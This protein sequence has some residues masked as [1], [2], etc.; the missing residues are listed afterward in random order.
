M[1]K[2]VIIFAPNKIDIYEVGEKG[3][4][5][6][7]VEMHEVYI[8]FEKSIKAYIDMSYIYDKDTMEA[9]T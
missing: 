6:I 3:V 7:L 8:Y 2:K 1:I 4:K 9:N 5:R